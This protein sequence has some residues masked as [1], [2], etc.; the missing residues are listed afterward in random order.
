[1]AT[2]TFD[3]KNSYS[4]FGLIAEE[5]KIQSPSKR[6]VK[7]TIPGMSGYLDF[8]TVISGGE[9]VYDTRP[10]TAKLFLSK[11]NREDLYNLYTRVLEWL[12]AGQS[13][14]IFDFMPGYYFL[15]EIE[16]APTW[17]EFVDNGDLEVKF[18]AQPYKY[19]ITNYGDL[20]WDNIDFSL[21]DYIQETTFS[22]NSSKTVTIYIPGN[23]S[24]IPSVVVNNDTSC[25]LNNYT[26]TFTTSKTTDWLFKLKPG[27]N[28]I[29]ITGNGN[30]EFQFR[31]EVL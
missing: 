4:D 22:V 30:I 9:Q 6:K 11:D 5:I 29:T 15:A 21:P 3:G 26:V 13:Q 19:S 7:E 14:L 27:A 23:H 20:L 12:G 2:F 8:S 1:M 28:N 18:T 10:I 16:D 24:I 25:T 31:K 17:D